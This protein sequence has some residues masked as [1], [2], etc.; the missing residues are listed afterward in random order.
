MAYLPEI[1]KLVLFGGMDGSWPPTITDTW[2]FDGT[3]WSPG[4][5][6]PAGLTPRAGARMA[7]DPDV[8]KL[9]LLG[10][11]GLD[12]YDDTWL[13]DGTAWSPGPAAPADMPPRAYFGMAYDPT[14]HRI[15]VAGGSGGT[16]VWNFDG[17]AWSRGTD[18]SAVGARERVSMDYDP[19]L[20]GIVLFGGIGP[21]YASNQLW[22]LRNGAWT[23]VPSSPTWPS[24][25]VDAPVLWHPTQDSLMT[26]G[27]I[28][29][30]RGDQ[31]FTDTWFF[32]DAP[33]QVASV[34][35]SPTAPYSFSYVKLA[36][37]TVTGGYG[38]LTFTYSWYV[39][40]VKVSGATGKTLV[41]G[42]FH[43]LDTIQAKVQVTDAIG[44]TGPE[45]ASP[46]ITV[47]DILPKVDWAAISPNP[48]YLTSTLTASAGP[49]HDG[50]GD[51]VTL[52]YGWTVDGVTVGGDAPT[53]A[54]ALFHG[55]SLVALA[56]TPVD[57]WGKSGTPASASATIQW[58]LSTTNPH[59]G[60]LVY[61]SGAGYSSSEPVDIR[62]DS[63][64]GTLIGSATT[65]ASG[66]FPSTSFVFPSP[67]AGG[68]HTVYGLGRTSGIVGLGQLTVVPGATISPSQLAAGATTTV[69]G[70][71]FV[72][73]ETVSASFPGGTAVQ[74]TAGSNGSV[75]LTMVSP[76]EPY[77]SGTISVTAPS[78]SASVGYTVK[79]L[80]TVP[81]NGTP[82]APGS[83]S[84]TGYG[85]SETAQVSFD[86]G[87]VAGSFTTDASGSGTATV[88]LPST[89]G[90]H[91]VQVT[92]LSS[93]VSLT[94]TFSL[95]ATMKIVPDSGPIGTVIT[96]DSGPGWVPGSTVHLRWGAFLWVQDLVADS[97]GKVHTTYTIPWS[98]PGTQKVWLID[99]VLGQSANAPF[100][101]TLE[102][103]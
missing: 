79:S 46:V 81:T 58:N 14:L 53:L 27:G 60:G 66:S 96:V 28:Q 48:A 70:L 15:V 86:G 20:G 78:G 7:Y 1:G 2:L 82:G 101:V 3:A 76:P 45:A 67:V 11:S 69:T 100:T 29:D 44:L 8:H 75:A 43:P 55:G 42:N 35:L 56:I 49:V 89:F 31:G 33:P 59:P 25:R 54:P 99:D 23:Q 94:G 50:D 95:P 41:P 22:L 97:S 71:G 83:F 64:V 47:Q 73:G 6:A 4:P 74:G 68:A 92:G 30:G 9:V 98:P 61:F 84:V 51:T 77:P 102:R 5:A 103:S 62:L 10:G 38:K 17:S 88:T 52:H 85:G 32:R 34:T 13:F 21:G 12:S 90:S 26:F 87:P 24:A 19:D 16:D 72:P 65:N 91:T 39:S 57:Q 40:G 18:I 36:T 93:A 37:G 63:A 80:L